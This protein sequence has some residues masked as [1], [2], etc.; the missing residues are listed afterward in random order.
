MYELTRGQIPLHSHSMISDN[1]VHTRIV[2]SADDNHQAVDYAHRDEYYI[3]GI[4]THGSLRCDIDFRETTMRRG[5][6]HFI[7]PGQVHRLIDSHNIEGWMLMAEN[8]L[9]SDTDR[10]IFEKSSVKGISVSA[11]SAEIEEL[12]SLYMLIHNRLHSDSNSTVIRH[13]VSAFIRIFADK[14]QQ[15][16]NENPAGS[17]RYMEIILKLNALLRSDLSISHQ[18]SYYSDKLYIS[19]VYLNEVVNSVTGCSTSTYIRNEII[20]QAKRLLYHTNMNV[21]EIASSLGFDDN[22]YFTRLFTKSTGRSP[23]KFRQNP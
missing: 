18:P 12:K 9:I 2:T 19:P 17:N 1:G 3:F 7:C 11:S 5:E 22:A 10:I 23:L 20:L 16:C 13:L 6:L 4:I 14:Y 15:A 8:S 21:K